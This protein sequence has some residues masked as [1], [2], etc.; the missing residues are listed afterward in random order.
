MPHSTAEPLVRHVVLE[1]VHDVALWPLS[2]ARE[3][4]ERHAVPKANEPD[5]LGGVVEEQLRGRYLP[6]ADQDAVRRE[7]AEH[8]A[9]ARALGAQLHEVVVALAVRDEA[10]EHEELGATA[11]LLRREARGPDDRVDPLVRGEGH[12]PHAIGVQIEERHLDGLEPVE[13]ERRLVLRL[14]GRVRE[15]ADAP[16]AAHEQAT[17]LPHGVGVHQHVRDAQVLESRLKSV[18][19]LVEDHRHLVDDAHVAL[20]LDVG[21]DGVGLRALHVVLR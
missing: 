5:L 15:V 19:L 12:S 20:E 1:D 7:L 3:L 14:V 16:H 13:Q 21:L 9:L 17:V 4:V 2:L 10:R 6:A 8:V 11:Q 18:A